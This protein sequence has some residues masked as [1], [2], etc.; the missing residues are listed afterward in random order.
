MSLTPENKQR[1]KVGI[2]LSVIDFVLIGLRL[3]YFCSTGSNRCGEEYMLGIAHMPTILLIEP[4]LYKD[5]MLTVV[6]IIL[7]GFIQYFLIGYLL[8]YFWQKVIK[9][10]V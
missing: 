1:I 10:R 5:K 3:I 7:V 6:L 9:S 2:V 4:F 8:T